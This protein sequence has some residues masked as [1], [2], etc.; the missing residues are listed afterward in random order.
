MIFIIFV[1]DTDSEEDKEGLVLF[2]VVKY[3]N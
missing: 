2:D 3:G 1:G